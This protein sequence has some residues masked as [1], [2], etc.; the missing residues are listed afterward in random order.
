M[1]VQEGPSF[2]RYAANGIATV[3]S[4]PFLLLDDE[5]LVVTLDGVEVTSGFTLSGIGNPTSSATFDV[6]PSGDLL[7]LLVIPF[8]RLADYQ[9]NGDFLASTV[10]N[11]FDRIWLA[12]KELRRDDQRALS[13]D[14]L[15]P[16]GIPPLPV[17]ALRQS[18]VLSFDADGDP[19]PSNLTLAQ[20]E[21]Q[22]ALAL[23]SAAAAQAS[24]EA[25]ALSETAAGGHASAA[26]SSAGTAATAA[27]LASRWADE[28]EDVPVAVGPNRF[29]AMHWAIKAAASL[30]GLLARV[31]TLE[32]RQLTRGTVQST[33]SGT[34]KDFTGIPAGTRQFTLMLDGVSTN[35]TSVLQVQLGAGSVVTSGYNASRIDTAGAG[36]IATAAMATGFAAYSPAAAADLCHG[37]L[38]FTNLSGNIWTVSGG[39]S[40]TGGRSTSCY[41]AITLSGA[42]DRVRLT[43]VNGTD[44]FD[45]GS[46][47]IMWGGAA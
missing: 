6:A 36:N 4:I 9:L 13:V 7:F 1:A 25:A 19:V 5:D 22:P 39:F 18:R 8:Q 34:S 11:D 24:A 41:G 40:G 27:T 29:S 17:A 43:T 20:I 12:L 15:E 2:K 16:E 14:P 35:G 47:N 21:E 23:A 30:A 26:S 33:T 38:V 46:A 44:A 3:Y 42:L 31:G 28:A 32:G 45:G 37:Q 10:N